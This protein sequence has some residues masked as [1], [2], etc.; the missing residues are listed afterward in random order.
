MKKVIIRK[1]INN[2]GDISG[3]RMPILKLI[4][5]AMFN[6]SYSFHNFMERQI[7][8][9]TD[10]MN[11]LEEEKERFRKLGFTCFTV[12]DED[13]KFIVEDRIQTIDKVTDIIISCRLLHDDELSQYTPHGKRSMTTPHFIIQRIKN[14]R[15]KL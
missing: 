10:A 7:M 6:I 15:V 5:T 14:I 9:N 12:F 4:E 2:L 8:L 3:D 11:K 13:I 1:T